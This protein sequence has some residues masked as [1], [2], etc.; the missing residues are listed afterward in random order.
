[1]TNTA[2]TLDRADQGADIGTDNER[3]EQQKYRDFGSDL[4]RAAGTIIPFAGSL[5]GETIIESQEV[6]R[7]PGVAREQQR[8]A[9]EASQAKRRAVKQTKAIP[10]GKPNETVT[11][12]LDNM[13]DYLNKSEIAR[14]L[15]KKG[16]P[17]TQVAPAFLKVF[18]ALSG[19]TV[20]PAAFFD[21][22]SR[23]QQL[24]ESLKFMAHTG[25]RSDGKPGPL[26]ER[27]LA[28]GT[29]DRLRQDPEMTR[30]LNAEGTISDDLYKSLF[31]DNT[32]AQR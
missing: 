19:A 32:V 18:G 23:G 8:A 15:T 30:M 9:G 14:E 22:F 28:A 10:S 17:I 4:A 1:M 6:E 26:Q 29:L 7:T 21:E 12:A 5:A 2:E 11:S 20:V 25:Y 13:R 16:A 3:F 24:P 31:A 27:D